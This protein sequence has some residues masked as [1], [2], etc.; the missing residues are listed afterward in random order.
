MRVVT[1]VISKKFK[2]SASEGT[3]SYL[4]NRIWETSILNSVLDHMEN[5][6]LEGS[7]AAHYFLVE[8]PDVWKKWVGSNAQQKIKDSL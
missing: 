2:D 8:Y 1:S 7:D 6:K 3:L 4:E 5:N